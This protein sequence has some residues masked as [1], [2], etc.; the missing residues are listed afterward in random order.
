MSTVFVRVKWF[1]SKHHSK[2]IIFCDIC[3]QSPS[4]VNLEGSSC[5]NHWKDAPVL[6]EHE[7]NQQ[8]M[9]LSRKNAINEETYLDPVFTTLCLNETR[10]FCCISEV[11]VN[12]NSDCFLLHLNF[13]EFWCHSGSFWKRLASVCSHTC[14]LPT[15]A[16]NSF[17]CA[18]ASR[19]MTSTAVIAEGCSRC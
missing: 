2:C 11:C 12:N 8:V 18:C 13:C 6:P 4:G 16:V 5:L 10:H 15:A 9:N 14:T 3:P 1:C 7:F 19:W 17:F